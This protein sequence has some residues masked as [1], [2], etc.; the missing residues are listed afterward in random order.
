ML[1]ASFHAGIGVGKMPADVAETGGAENR[2]GGRM[3]RD[4]AVRMAERAAVGRERHAAD[5]ERPSV[6]EPVQIVARADPRRRRRRPSAA[7]PRRDRPPS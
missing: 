3:A 2:V 6:D 4:V 7:A 1:S 5:D